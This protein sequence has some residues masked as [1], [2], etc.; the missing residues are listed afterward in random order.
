MKKVVI[1]LAA[2]IT[3]ASCESNNKFLE[4]TPNGSL[5]PEN[6]LNNGTEIQMML[7]SLYNLWD[8]SMNRPYQSMEIKYASADDVLGTG[9]QRACYNEMEINMRTKPDLL[10]PYEYARAYNEVNG[11]NSISADDL[12]AYKSGTKGIDW[13]D[14]MTQTGFSQNY[15]LNISGGN[16]KTKYS[17]SGWVAD[18][19]GQW[20]TNTSR[21]YNV[22][23]TLDTNI[24][25][26]LEFT[27]YM[28]DGLTKQ[29]NSSDQDQ[30]VDVLEY[31]PCMELQSASG[32][33]N[34]DPY[35]SIG[36]NPYASVKAE[37]T[38][39]RSSTMTMHTLF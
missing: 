9:N 30:F 25:P 16:Q 29:H 6:F 15:N 27:G 37:W 4:E 20:I 10:S 5:F 7:N 14:L 38:D 3:F 35:G 24:T 19:K 12:A 18:T 17:V 23:A 11:A 13:V 31:S 33:Y 28:Y 32:I 8:T 34:L 1:L 26:W 39:Y 22:K 36:S 21:N 2:I